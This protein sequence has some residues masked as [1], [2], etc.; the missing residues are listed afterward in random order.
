MLWCAVPHEQFAQHVQNITG[1][2]PSLDTDGETLARVLIDHAQ[3][4]EDLSVM[5]AVLNEVI[6]PDVPFVGGS[7][8]DA[9]SIIEPEPPAFWLFLRNFEPLTP[10][11]PVHTSNTDLPAFSIKKR[12]DPTV[13]VATNLLS[14]IDDCLGE[15]RLIRPRCRQSSLC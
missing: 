1:V 4:S 2:E 5:R 14:Q 8:A 15:V 6:G 13:T 11:Y 3:H 7:E 9:G 12:C 10:P